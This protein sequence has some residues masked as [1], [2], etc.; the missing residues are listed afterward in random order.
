[1]RGTPTPATP[2]RDPLK[3]LRERRGVKGLRWD[4]C[5]TGCMPLCLVPYTCH[6]SS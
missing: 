6:V 5:G 4:Q 1:M 2:R 3:E